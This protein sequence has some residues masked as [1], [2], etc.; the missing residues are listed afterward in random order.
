MRD[1]PTFRPALK[2]VKR[3]ILKFEFHEVPVKFTNFTGNSVK[4]EI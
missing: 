3:E 4:F 2:K 1:F